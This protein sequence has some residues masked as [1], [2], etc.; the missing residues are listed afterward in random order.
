MR[1]V[2]VADKVEEVEELSEEEA[3]WG[4]RFDGLIL[5]G[6]STDDAERLCHLTDVVA[7]ARALTER[8]CPAEV[9]TRILLP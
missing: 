3:L 6:F 4:F 1:S 9:A 7:R 8:G 2:G 5:L